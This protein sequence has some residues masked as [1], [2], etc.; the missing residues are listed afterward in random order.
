MGFK[1]ILEVPVGAAL[2]TKNPGNANLGQASVHIPL[3]IIGHDDVLTW[4]QPDQHRLSAYAL[5]YPENL[6]EYFDG[7]AS[8]NDPIDVEYAVSVC[9]GGS[10][11]DTSARGRRGLIHGWPCCRRQL[12]ISARCRS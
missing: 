1:L 12:A 7:S 3:H 5:A 4:T 8:L 11:S 2:P 9:P 6:Q 10:P